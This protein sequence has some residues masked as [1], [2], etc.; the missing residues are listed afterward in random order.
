MNPQNPVE[1]IWLQAKNFLRKYW[2][3]C[4]SFWAIKKLF[5]LF[6]DSSKFDF[7]KIRQDLLKNISV[8][9]FEE[10]ELDSLLTK[11]NKNICEKLGNDYQIGH[12]YFMDIKNLEDLRFVWYYRIM[13]LLQ[14]HFY[15]DSD[16]LKEIIGE[17]L[18]QTDSDL[19]DEDFKI[20]LLELSGT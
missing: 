1:D 4:K 9:D 2:Y 7:P 3:L 6:Y 5:Q 20:A 18:I 10:I 14:E 11:L 13:P 17:N 12:S 15:H 16:R 8:E 19:D